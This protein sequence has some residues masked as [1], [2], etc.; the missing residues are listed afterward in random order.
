MKNDGQKKNFNRVPRGR[1]I[2]GRPRRYK[3]ITEVT[4][5][6]AWASVEGCTGTREMGIGIGKKTIASNK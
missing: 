6:R 2:R 3:G 5:P 1:N 4:Y